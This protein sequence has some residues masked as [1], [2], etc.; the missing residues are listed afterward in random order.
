M[1][2]SLVLLAS[3]LLMAFP[4]AA[5]PLQPP[6]DLAL[7]LPPAGSP[8]SEDQFLLA[9]SSLPRDAALPGLI[10]NAARRHPL[11]SAAAAATT[12]ALAEA[13][14]ARAALLPRVEASLS[15]SRALDRDFSGS[16][17]I[18]ESVIPRGRADAQIGL[19]APLIEAGNFGRLAAARNRQRSA[20]LREGDALAER[21]LAA[22]SAHYQCLVLSGLV[23]LADD[24]LARH[25]Q[26]RAATAERVAAGLAP[27]IDL[28]RA[29]QGEAGAAQDLA[30][31]GRALGAARARA[32]AAGL[33]ETLPHA[34]LPL[35][36]EQRHGLAAIRAGAATTPAVAAARAA[37]EAARAEA[38]AAR[39]DRLPTLAA[40]LTATRF[41]AFE[42]GPNQ[43][44]RGQ[45]VLRQRLSLGG[46]EQA[47]I[48]DAEAR[49]RAAEA[50]ADQ[51]LLAAEAEAETALAEAQ[52]L[53]AD[54]HALRLGYAADRAARDALA[55]EV[56][57]R[58]G[59]L[60]ELVRAED[61]LAATAAALWQ[62]GLEADL[63]AV[64]L[65]AATGR[66]AAVL[67]LEELSR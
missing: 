27:G 18:L 29:E 48:R 17:T 7:H 13:R 46:A 50:E 39:A 53:H 26:L 20:T 61:A 67:G 55:E 63:A 24:R 32:H 38:R 51:A 49:A 44:I 45:L 54:L 43:E 11:N 62:A 21:A 58:R 14:L 52:G 66:L 36:A 16:S 22:V 30:R 5:Q 64:R 59:G 60:L 1:M 57:L 19:E 25:R 33:P 28:V 41:N 4:L 40:A 6:P 2:H 65:A 56:R 42:A 15:A 37:A 34:R 23:S 35:P 8:P 12:S 10:A 31:L 47:R 3:L 9:V